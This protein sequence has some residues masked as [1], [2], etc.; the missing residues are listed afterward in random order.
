MKDMRYIDDVT[1]LQLH[2]ELCI[3]CGL[4]I[5]VCPQSVLELL[6]GKAHIVDKNSC[7]ECG[8]CVNNCPV[9]AVEV[10]PGVG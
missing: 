6:G 4:C 7:M 9:H 1:T 2:E 3:G 5:E 8:A 10:H